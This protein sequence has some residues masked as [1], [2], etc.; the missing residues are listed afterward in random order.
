MG[1]VPYDPRMRS[2]SGL[3]IIAVAI[4]TATTLSTML[5]AQGKFGPSVWDG[6]FTAAQA[7]RG[8]R[9]YADHCAECHGNNCAVLC[10]MCEDQA[11]LLV[12]RPNQR[13]SEAQRPAACEVCGA[14]VWRPSKNQFSE[15][16]E[17]TEKS[18]SFGR[19]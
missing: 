4:F 5:Q 10:P 13:G 16:G 1:M 12:A 2:F 17:R 19:A 7:Q 9:V 14:E 18:I 8:A 3:L 15:S 6:T 11:V